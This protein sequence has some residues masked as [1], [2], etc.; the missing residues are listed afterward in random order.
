MAMFQFGSGVLLGARTDIANSTPVNFGLIQEVQLD[1]SFTTKELYGQNQFAVAIARGTAKMTGKAKMA[2]VSG[3]AFNNLFFGTNVSGGYTAS[4]I[5]EAAAVP[6]SSPYTVTV[7]HAATFIADYGVV[8]AATGLPL[9]LAASSPDAGAY[10]VS[11]GVYTF[12]SGDA[13]KAVLINYIYTAASGGQKIA[14]V[15]Q[16]IGTTPTF[17]AQLYTTFQGKTATVSLYNCVS[18]KLSYATKLEDFT[19]P[20]LDFSVFANADG[21]VLDWSFS[22]AS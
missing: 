15:N 2:Q 16:P 13:G 9:T 20:E 3:L 14:F 8:Y 7:A 5:G 17:S 11:A 22:E 6:A 4:S 10:S 19:I 21:N 1:L 18:S 12:S